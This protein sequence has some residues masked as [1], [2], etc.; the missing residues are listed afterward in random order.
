MDTLAHALYGATLCS[1]S[2]LPGALSRRP[3]ASSLRD[4]TLWA[5]FGFGLLPDLAS[6]GVSF[7][8]MM[9]N[10][11]PPSFHGIPP[12][13][14]VLYSCT[15]SLVVAG[16]LVAMLRVAAR[17]LALPALAWPIHIV[18]DSFTH[19]TGRWQT[20][21]FYPL[22]DW[23]FDGVNWWENPGVALAYWG[24]LPVLWLAIALIRRARSSTS[25]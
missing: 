7:A 16:L 9:V 22:S 11:A 20:P 13:V 10:G 24:M 3:S 1:R 23:H 4:W 8:R 14:F 5:A 17:P 6:I 25:S 12:Y 2:G 19:G 15:H 21:L 18:M